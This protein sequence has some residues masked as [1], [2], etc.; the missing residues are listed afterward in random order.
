MKGLFTSEL[1]RLWSQKISWIILFFIP[2]M[3]IGSVKYYLSWNERVSPGQPDYVTSLNFPII[4]ISEHLVVSFNIIAIILISTV[5]ANEIE[6]GQ[7]RMILIRPFSTTQ[8]FLAK[9]ATILT[10]MFLYLTLFWIL[11]TVAGYIFFPK[12]DTLITFL[13]EQKLSLTA[14]LLY[15]VKYFSACFVT[16]ISVVSVFTLLGSISRST[17]ITLGAGVGF[18]FLSIAIP[19]LLEFSTQTIIGH[20]TVI[21]LMYMSIV[22]IQHTGIAFLLSSTNNLNSY[23]ILV[24]T[25][26]I[27]LFGL[28]AYW[29]FVKRDYFI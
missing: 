23:I 10:T 26:Y 15:N 9:L 1:E 16:M 19:Q 4:S 17:M 29:T 11:N 12:V 8:L 2:L 5:I 28:I 14:A 18:I 25:V 27:A 22:K 24:Q 7:L 3:S 13:D 20:S 21:H 6:N